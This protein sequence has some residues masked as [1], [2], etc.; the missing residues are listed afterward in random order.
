MSLNFLATRFQCSWPWSTLVML[1]DGRIVCG[2]ADPYG[3]RV[4]GDAR[5]STIHDVWTGDVVSQLRAD[6]NAGGSK[7][8]G[9]CPL[10]LPLK[11]DETPPMRSPDAGR[12]PSR[13]YVECTAACNISCTEA[14]CAPET[15]ITRTRQAGMLD[16]DLFQRVVDEVGASLVR[17]DFFNY[18][19]AFLHKRAVE[20]CEYIKSRFP[21][22]YLYTSTNGLALS[23]AQARRLVHSGIDEVTFSI[24]G[25]TQDS[26]V[27]YRQRGRFDVA[28]ANLR[29]MADEKRQAGRDVPFLNWRYIL[30]TWND[31]DEEMARARQLAAQIGVDRLCWELT[32]H[33]ENAYSRRFVPGAP[34]LEAIRH[35]I[36]DDNNLG[37]AIPGATPSARIEVGSVLPGAGRLPLIARAGRALQVNTRVRNLSTRAFPAQ[38]SYGRR[39]VRLGAQLCAA[40]GTIINRDL[41]RAWLPQPLGPGDRADIAIEIPAPE[42]PGRYALKFDLVSEGIDWFEACG[43]QTT[44]RT[45]W[46]R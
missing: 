42:Q 39:L 16:F 40:D 25:A 33:P 38:A 37:N 43:S 8:C 21:Q 30:F 32:D 31:S 28:I 10:K 14:C 19:E 23:E 44:T 7:F 4:L 36:W 3:K 18:G 13:M 2:C 6:L 29:A 12:H 1:C 34:E 20:M 5:Q 46:V 22:I 26:Y 15:G 35:E 41:A 45:L 9:D 27:K 11:K 17:I 24:D